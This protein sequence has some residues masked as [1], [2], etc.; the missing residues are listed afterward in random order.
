M[1]RKKT[2]TPEEAREN[3]LKSKRE[4]KQKITKAKKSEEFLDINNITSD[5][6]DSIVEKQDIQQPEI[7]IE[8]V[9]NEK[10]IMFW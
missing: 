2:L 4:Y 9:Y 7:Q 5:S 8:K 10:K 6:G 1:S 3:I